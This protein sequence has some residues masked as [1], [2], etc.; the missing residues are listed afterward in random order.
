LDKGV[1]SLK[2]AREQLKVY[3]QALLKH[4]FEGKFTEQ[5]RKAHA[6]ELET[7][8]ELLERIRE[9]HKHWIKDEISRGNQE[10]KRLVGKLNKHIHNNPESRIPDAW[11]WTSL[12]LACNQVVDCHN[13]TAPYEKAGI[14]LVR[15]SN[16]RDGKLD[17]ENDIRYV[18]EKT[19]EYWS[20]RCPPQSGD[21]LF[22]REAPMGQVTIIPAST[23]VCMGQ[24]MMLLRVYSN[25]L[26]QK[27][28]LYAIQEPLFQ[29]RILS[30]A[31]GTGVKHLRVGDVERLIFPL[32]SYDEQ[33]EISKEI[34]TYFS[35]AD[36]LNISIEENL[37]KA[38][39]LRQSILKKAF[40]GQLV[41]QDLND[42]PTSILLERIRAE[43]KA[44]AKP[45]RDRVGNKKK[46]KISTM[47]DLIEVLE[48]ANTWLSARDVFRQCGIGDGAKTDIIEKLYFELRDYI[49]AERLEVERRGD[50]DW[51]RIRPTKE[52]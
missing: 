12:L 48:S 36:M 37:Q 2:V 15:T 50:E 44:A 16:V 8:D 1:E 3:R 20:R 28:L 39:A 5:W 31:V 26:D 23:K 47:A 40:S 49:S 29:E 27:Y 32:C 19:Y 33:K 6:D 41:P 51:L 18:S 52:K 24:R 25:L 42:E 22:T 13:K 45:I 11:K 14:Y 43:R 17:L 4:A 21:L 9:E 35:V 38:E 30:E 34:D 7:P 10:A 46:E